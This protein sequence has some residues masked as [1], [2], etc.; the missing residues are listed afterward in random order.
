MMLDFLNNPSDSFSY[1]GSP[2]AALI[3]L[4]QSNSSSLT[5]KVFLP[6]VVAEI[7][8]RLWVVSRLNRNPSESFSQKA[9]RI[10]GQ[11]TGAAVVIAGLYMSSLGCRDEWQER[12]Q[13]EEFARRNEADL[14]ALSASSAEETLNPI[15]FDPD[16][17]WKKH[18]PISSKG[19]DGPCDGN[20]ALQ[21]LQSS[22]H[23]PEGIRFDRGLLAPNLSFGNCSAS[24]LNFVKAVL[25]QCPNKA[26]K[27]LCLSSV[28]RKFQY[29][30]ELSRS[31]QSAFN[32]IVV[33]EIGSD[34]IRDKV[35]ALLNLHDLEIT[36]A[37][38][39]TV[40]LRE[41]APPKMVMEQLAD[42]VGQGASFADFDVYVI[43][44]I[45]PNPYARKLENWGHTTA[46]LMS[47][48]LVAYYDPAKDGGL[49]V[50]P[51]RDSRWVSAITE[52]LQA[53][54]DAY[55]LLSHRIFQVAFRGK[56]ETS[57]LPDNL[58]ASRDGLLFPSSLGLSKEEIRCDGVSASL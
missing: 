33:E 4:D 23:L 54:R 6:L 35:Q 47:N 34:P 7:G 5:K 8:R 38:P 30:D 57:L 20:E 11:A 10:L 37:V 50:G 58:D 14:V 48:D 32:T 27:E 18:V 2:V 29:P 39:E 53:D 25:E 36:R 9:V 43:R 31:H 21:K 13:A 52:G 41:Q 24:T 19:R 56:G 44:G 46:L 45:N 17:F 40:S 42:R 26:E 51:R 49:F 55:H 28:M 3:L 22:K 16:S 1:F 15:V 12:A